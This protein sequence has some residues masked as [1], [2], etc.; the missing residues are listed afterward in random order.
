M[1]DTAVVTGRR[2]LDGAIA[3][4]LEAHGHRLPALITAM[5]RMR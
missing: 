5:M 3:M 1:P 2:G 4:A